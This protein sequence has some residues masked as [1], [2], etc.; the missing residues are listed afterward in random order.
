ME[1]WIRSQDKSILTKVD[2]LRLNKYIVSFGSNT[3]EYDITDNVYLLGRY[4]N[5]KR[6]LEVLDEIQ[7]A[8]RNHCVEM[9]TDGNP[10]RRWEYYYNTSIVYE[11]PKE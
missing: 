5:E 11:M 2:A 8:I 3:G 9:Q 4:E 7:S 1:L 10:E 6:A